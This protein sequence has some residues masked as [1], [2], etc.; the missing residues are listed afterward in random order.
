MAGLDP[1]PEQTQP[2]RLIRRD[3]FDHIEK[4]F[5]RWCGMDKNPTGTNLRSTLPDPGA[6]QAVTPTVRSELI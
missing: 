1:L 3:E 4:L 2:P 5:G 6:R